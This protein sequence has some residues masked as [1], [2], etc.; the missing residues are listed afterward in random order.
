MGPSDSRALLAAIRFPTVAACGREDRVTPWPSEEPTSAI[1]GAE[2][3]LLEECGHL[4][5]LERPDQV[6]MP[7]K[8]WLGKAQ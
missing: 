2:R 1:P 3:V 7:L 4:S 8:D 6:S 5:P